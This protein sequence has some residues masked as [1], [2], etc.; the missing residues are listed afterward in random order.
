M[1]FLVLVALLLIGAPTAHAADIV[2]VTAA[3]GWSVYG[4]KV[5]FG[6][7]TGVAGGAA[8]IVEATETTDP[9]SS[10]A[11]AAINAPVKAGETY[12]AVV[13]LRAP[14]NAKLSALLLT[15][16]PPYP[17][18]TN[19]EI[20]GTGNWKRLTVMGVAKADAEAGRDAVALHLGHAGG[21]VS[22]GPAVV[23]RGTPTPAE[24]DSV[25]KAYKPDRIAEDVTLTAPDGLK[26]A[27][28]LRIPAGKGPFPAVVM[29]GGSGPQVRGAFR[30]LHARLLPDGVA[31]LEYD[32]RGSGESG[33]PANERLPVLADD[34][35][36]MVG[37]LRSRP[38]IDPTRIVVVGHSQG[39]MVAAQVAGGSDAP[40]G[41][42]LLLSPATSGREHTSDQV[43]RSL[44]MSFPQGGS[45]AVQRR[46]ADQLIDA[47]AAGGDQAAMRSRVEL[48]VAAGVKDGRIPQEAAEQ[49]TTALSDAVQLPA[50]LERRPAEDLRR[51]RIPVLA[52]YGGKDTLV[53]A[54]VHAP[55]ARAALAGDP[56]AEIVVLPTLNHALQVPWTDDPEEWRTRP[57]MDG[58]EVR[59]L[60]AGWVEKTLGVRPR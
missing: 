19:I 50:A 4:A 3:D 5:R 31:T 49:I 14:A 22:L 33:G 25:T 37:F 56:R 35:R 20:I 38:E 46:F 30:V 11:T 53:P 58:E 13:W 32:K 8:A 57:A 10:G 28:T 43:A 16:A 21:P 51:V 48:V 6:R 7:D 2:S 45:Y 23:L 42:V 17:T 9:W 47:A 12:T 60:V 59:E 36:A 52:V 29:V 55:A 15:N 34:V 18:F 40:R 44:V 41:V 39:G 27:A 24:L 54:D 1:K 26:L